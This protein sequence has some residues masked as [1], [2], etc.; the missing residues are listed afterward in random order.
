MKSKIQKHHQ[1]A[2]Y[3][4]GTK[5]D[6]S[7]LL[8]LQKDSKKTQFLHRLFQKL[9]RSTSNYNHKKAKKRRR[10]YSTSSSDSNTSAESYA[11][12]SSN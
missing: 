7:L 3:T 10:T 6:T 1:K 4:S 11:T 2:T 12:S 8:Q 9:Q 5:D